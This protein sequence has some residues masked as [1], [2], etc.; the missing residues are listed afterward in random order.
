[1]SPMKPL[2]KTVDLS[3]PLAMPFQLY[4]KLK[5]KNYFSTETVRSL[6][7]I[8]KTKQN[9]NKKS[10][11]NFLFSENFNKNL[12]SVIM[13]SLLCVILKFYPTGLLVLG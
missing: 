1:M 11:L 10:H 4:L 7:Y 5:F 6:Q 2:S 3:F 9:N 12:S 13:T 8:A